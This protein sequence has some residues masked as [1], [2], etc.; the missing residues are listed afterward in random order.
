MICTRVVIGALVIASGVMGH[1]YRA[2][3]ART[4]PTTSAEATSPSV[5]DTAVSVPDSGDEG[6]PRMD[7]YGNEV[8]D[9]VGDYRVDGTGD[10]YESHSPDTE[11]ARLGTP[12][13]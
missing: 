7:V 1:E 10:L 2:I 11:V 9:A 5:S 4:A 3:E 13:A 12:G 8:E 6:I